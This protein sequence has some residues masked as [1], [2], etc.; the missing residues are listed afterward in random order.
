LFLS[1][2]DLCKAGEIFDRELRLVDEWLMINKLSLN[3][4][5]T[6]HMIISHC[7]IPDDFTISIRDNRVARVSTAKFLG[8]YI[9]D[10]LSFGYHIDQLCKKISRSVGVLYK[11]S[12][13]VPSTVLTNLYY[14]LV[15]SNLIYGITAWSGSANVHMNRLSVL[16]IRAFHVTNDDGCLVSKVLNVSNLY[17]YLCSIKF[18]KSY[19]MGSHEHFA[20]S[21]ANLL[22]SHNYSTRHKEAGQ[23]NIPLYH[24]SKCQQSFLFNSSKTWNTI[25]PYVRECDTLTKFKNSLKMYFLGCQQV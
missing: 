12:P 1:D 25:P 9:D 7:D 8:V 19:R 24:K 11:L 13:L 10:K 5:K 16:Q 18:Y 14:A 23:L 20:L 17:K 3:L 21:I 15:H 4:Q 2:A 6:T 22:P